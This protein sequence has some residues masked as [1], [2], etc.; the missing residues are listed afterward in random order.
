M[1]TEKLARSVPNERIIADSCGV[2]TASV[3]EIS[4]PT[5]SKCIP[6]RNTTSTASG[7]THILNSATC[8]TLPM[9]SAT[10]PM[11]TQRLTVLAILGSFCNAS[12]MLVSGPS[13]TNSMWPALACSASMSLSM[14]FPGVGVRPES[15]RPISPIPSSPCTNCAVPSSRE[16]GF[17]A[18]A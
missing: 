7:S 10:A 5:N 12:A 1:S 6:D 13:V 18:P 4:H 8:V 3:R 9:W 14:P 15:G 11:I 16:S 17:A 2:T